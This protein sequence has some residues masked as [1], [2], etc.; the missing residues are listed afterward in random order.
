MTNNDKVR[1]TVPTAQPAESKAEYI[2]RLVN[3]AKLWSRFAEEHSNLTKHRLQGIAMDALAFSINHRTKSLAIPSKLV[4]VM[5]VQDVLEAIYELGESRVQP[6]AVQHEAGKICVFYGNTRLGWIWPKHSWLWP[7]MAA[8]ARVYM[9]KITG[10][11][12]V[13]KSLGCNIAIGH[14][15]EAIRVVEG[16]PAPTVVR[17]EQGDG[18]ASDCDW[19]AAIPTQAR[20]NGR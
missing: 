20:S 9:T 11:D 1:E 15:A 6:L 3:E 13:W 12:E 19:P 16:G 8:G 14:V 7:L 17:S 10:T 5:E 2:E 18:S 4:G